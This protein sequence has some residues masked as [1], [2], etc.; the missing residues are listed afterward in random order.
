LKL[1]DVLRHEEPPRTE[2]FVEIPSAYGKL[3]L[4]IM[5][6][7]GEALAQTGM[8]TDSARA[9]HALIDEAEAK[10]RAGDNEGGL[11]GL[12][13]VV[14]LYPYSV[15]GYG[16]LYNYYQEQGNRDETIYYLQQRIALDPQYRFLTMLGKELG[17]AGRYDEALLSQSYLWENRREAT[18]KEARDAACDYLATLDRTGGAKKMIEVAGEAMNEM[19][20]DSTLMYQYIYAR[21]LDKQYSEARA[22]L[23]RVLPGLKGDDPLYSRFMDMSNVVDDLLTG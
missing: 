7:V 10:L 12:I 19:G 13:E 1:I 8:T 3:R 17:R 23:N 5:G 18:G 21:I 22:L 16:V 14:K 9:A 11:N 4:D 20:N 2:Y 15:D 6:D